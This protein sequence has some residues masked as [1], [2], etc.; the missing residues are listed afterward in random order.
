MYKSVEE[1][2][3]AK[4]GEEKRQDLK[5]S[6]HQGYSENYKNPREDRL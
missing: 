5:G 2:H 6:C 4:A 1:M 3:S